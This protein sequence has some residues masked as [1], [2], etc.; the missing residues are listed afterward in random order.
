MGL[1]LCILGISLLLEGWKISQSLFQT[2]S[3]TGFVIGTFGCFVLWVGLWPRE[4][5]LT[6]Q[7]AST[8]QYFSYENEL[9]AAE[10]QRVVRIAYK[11][12][13]GNVTKRDV[14]VYHPRDDSYMYGYC[15]LRKEPRT[16]LIDN[17]LRWEMLPEKFVFNPLVKEWFET[18]GK[19]MGAEREDWEAWVIQQRRH[20]SRNKKNLWE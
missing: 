8:S 15:R 11:D 17:I 2:E 14:E 6:A 5:S 20:G 10:N 3:I 13:S 16:F 19:K 1:F 4:K 7:T 9:F 12:K 18:E